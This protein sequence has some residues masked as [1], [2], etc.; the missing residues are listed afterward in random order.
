LIAIL[1]K[2]GSGGLAAQGLDETAT[3]QWLRIPKV[4]IQASE[5]NSPCRQ[6]RHRSPGRHPS[7]FGF[8]DRVFERYLGAF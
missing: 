8:I 4:A 2:F 3:N 5:H 1:A 7:R 6:S